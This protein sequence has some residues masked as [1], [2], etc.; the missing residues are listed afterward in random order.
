MSKRTNISEL[1]ARRIQKLQQQSKQSWSDLDNMYQSVAE[2]I[3]EIGYAVNEHIALAAGL[4][5][6]N[7]QELAVI[8]KGIQQDIE[9]FTEDLIKIRKRHEGKTGFITDEDELALCF[10][11]FNDY[12][13]L[14]DR[15]SAITLNPLLTIT[16]TITDAVSKL[17]KATVKGEVIEHDSIQ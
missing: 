11:I 8:V 5:I 17:Q 9:I 10:S 1:D 3:C 15:F 16:E 14:Y 6:E 13:A 4:D 7:P 2:G 12:Q